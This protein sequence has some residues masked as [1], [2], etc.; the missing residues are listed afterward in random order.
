[1]AMHLERTLG[2]IRGAVLRAASVAL[3]LGVAGCDDLLKVNDTVALGGAQLDDPA[4][5]QLPGVTTWSGARA[6]VRVLRRSGATD[7]AGRT[8]HGVAA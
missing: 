8:G 2:R 4:L 5:E 1:M 6:A 3:V 7:G